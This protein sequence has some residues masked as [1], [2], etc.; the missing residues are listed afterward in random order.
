MVDATADAAHNESVSLVLRRERYR[1]LLAWLAVLVPVPL[2]CLGGALFL[3]WQI[4]GAPAATWYHLL[5][6]YVSFAASPTAAAV[7]GWRTSH[8]PLRTIAF[9]A[10]GFVSF[11]IWLVIYLEVHSWVTGVP[12]VGND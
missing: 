12:I 7:I 5:T 3:V 9:S 1:P 8:S 11:F 4:H 2:V 10:A 6:L